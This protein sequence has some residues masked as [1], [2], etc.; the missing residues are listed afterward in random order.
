MLKDNP[1][2]IDYYERYQEIVEEYNR[3]NKKDEIAV[4]FEKL[5]NLVNSL[6]EEQKRYLKEGFESDE[7]LTMFDLLIKESLTKDEI[8]KI[9]GLAQV[10]LAKVKARIH[11]LENWRE[12]E[13]TCSIIRTLIR[14]LL[15]TSLP[16]SY[17]EKAVSEYNQS[18]YEYVYM[19]YPAA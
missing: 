15:W 6:D 9:K 10:M 5:M 3:D 18:I 4:T 11:E 7:E 17:D 13:E 16:E 8:K 1:L 12:K 2:R 14:D 19:A